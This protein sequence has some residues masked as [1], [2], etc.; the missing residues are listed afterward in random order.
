MTENQPTPPVERVLRLSERTVYGVS[1]YYPANATSEI[2][3]QIAKTKSLTKD[4][5]ECVRR[6]GYK[7]VRAK[8]DEKEINLSD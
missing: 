8:E 7:I 2:F 3:C 1:K 5:L 4:V 6:L